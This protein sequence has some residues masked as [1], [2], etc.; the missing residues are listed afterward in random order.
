MFFSKWMTNDILQSI[1]QKYRLYK[2]LMNTDTD[3]TV[4]F[5]R[6]KDI[7][8]YESELRTQNSEFYST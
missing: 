1:N 4:L 3:N 5:N 7:E 8:S 2:I 6:W